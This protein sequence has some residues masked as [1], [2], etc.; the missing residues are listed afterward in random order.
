[1]VFVSKKT[2]C[3]WA[4]VQTYKSVKGKKNKRVNVQ[5]RKNRK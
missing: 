4:K 5:K 2:K 3:K 1:M